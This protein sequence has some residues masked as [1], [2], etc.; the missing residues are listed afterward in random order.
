[1]FKTWPKE[2]QWALARARQ[3]RGPLVE[4]ERELFGFDHAVAGGEVLDAWRLPPTLAAM[5]RYHHSPDRAPQHPAEAAVMHVADVIVTSLELGHSGD[6]AVPRLSR[7]A[8][9]CLA[10]PAGTLVAVAAQAE[11]QV[12]EV[13]RSLLAGA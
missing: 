5:S 13:R 12:D 11:R 6:Q 2:A 8:W 9:D 10:L 7:A 1:M 4:I 3:T